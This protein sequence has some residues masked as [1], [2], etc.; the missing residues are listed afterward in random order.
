MNREGTLY[1]R[2]GGEQA[3]AA[4]VDNLYRRVL[5][6]P[7][8]QSFFKGHSLERI[9]SMQQELFCEAL[10]G[11]LRYSGKPISAVHHPLDIKMAHFQRFVGHVMAALEATGLNAEERSQALAALAVEADDVVGG[12]SNVAG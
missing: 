10:G 9:L 5:A 11:P 7:D 1:E 6:D 8:L 12:R 2:I 4:L 3:V